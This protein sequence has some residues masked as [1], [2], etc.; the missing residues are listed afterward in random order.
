MTSVFDAA[1][2]LDDAIRAD[3]AADTLS[4]LCEALDRVFQLTAVQALRETPSATAAASP[5]PAGG[6]D[7]AGLAPRLDALAG[8]LAQSNF[9]ARDK[10]EEL[11]SLLR[12]TAAAEEGKRMQ[13]SM[14]SFD[15][16]G[17]LEALR[18]IRAKLGPS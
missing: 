10:T 2:K 6:V 1:L 11:V 18:A 17:A 16:R 13:A 7:L 9:A 3:A 12:G 4:A 15:F 8:L 14:A 5:S